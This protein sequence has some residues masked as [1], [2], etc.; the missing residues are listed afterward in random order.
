MWVFLLHP[1]SQM[2]FMCVRA[3]ESVSF[4]MFMY[5]YHATITDR[6]VYHANVTDRVVYHA[7]VTDWFDVIHA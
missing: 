3:Y 5:V 2:P 6:V 1:R 4:F 7:T